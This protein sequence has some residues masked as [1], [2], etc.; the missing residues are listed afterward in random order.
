MIKYLQF[1]LLCLI[2]GT[3]FAAIKIGSSST[4][5]MVGLAL[6]YGFAMLVLFP[7]IGLT[8]RRIRFDKSSLKMYGVVGFYS[9]GLS[10]LCTYWAMQ[11]IPSSL[12]AILW[13]TLPL[14]V[15]LFA[16]LMVPLEKLNARRLISIFIA[17]VGVILI[18]TD[19]NL[20]FN[21]EVLLGCL[22]V[23]LGV[24]MASYPNVYLKAKAKDYD[25]MALT[26]M[27]ILIGALIHLAGAILAG[28][29][30]DMSWS[31]RNI[32]A[33]AYLGVFGSAIAFF[34]YFSLLRKIEVVKLSFV[35]FLT[36]IIATL[37]GLTFLHEAVTL[38]EIFGIGFIFGGLFLYDFKKYYLYV[39][40]LKT[41]SRK[42]V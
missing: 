10:Y 5:P 31:A 19:Q 30:A 9:M 36:P 17:I 28:Q 20:V 35:T 37:I 16:H 41:F 3:T 12:S 32:G 8:R 1:L 40:R 38:D 15:G 11:F 2:W 39:K 13:A 6:R 33:A 29:F 7:V 25:P 42:A 21:V 22:V 24:V 27:S 14:F 23:L 34:L 4:P 26:A 18:L